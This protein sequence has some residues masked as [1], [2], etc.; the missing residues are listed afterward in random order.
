MRPRKN[1]LQEPSPSAT[2]AG[3][4]GDCFEDLFRPEPGG[5]G[6]QARVIMHAQVWLP[7]G[8]AYSASRTQDRAGRAMTNQ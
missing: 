2:S 5:H 6:Q 4:L 3:K 8:P 1:E 7:H